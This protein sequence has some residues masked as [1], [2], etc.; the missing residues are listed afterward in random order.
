MSQETVA[1]QMLSL[2]H[3]RI[4]G[5]AFA[6]AAVYELIKNDIDAE[7]GFVQRCPKCGHHSLRRLKPAQKASP[8]DSHWRCFECGNDCDEFG[9]KL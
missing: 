1:E 6:A 4:R 2:I 5:E 3:P 8:D 7:E 9:N